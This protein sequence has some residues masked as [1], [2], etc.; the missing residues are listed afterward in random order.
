MAK[1]Q[2]TVKWFDPRKGYGFVTAEDGK[3][4]FAH[5]SAVEKGRNY[6][7]FDDGDKVEFEI[8]TADPK[9]PAAKGIVLT[10]EE[11]PPRKKRDKKDDDAP[12]AAE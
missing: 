11:R 6:T 1:V 4:Y 5:F 3:E 2:G 8:D 12:Q 9:G 10:C 7:G